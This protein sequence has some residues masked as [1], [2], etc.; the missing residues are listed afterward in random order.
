MVAVVNLA[1]DYWRYVIFVPFWYC[2]ITVNI[3]LSLIRR[4]T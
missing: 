3:L 1:I 4:N 2:T